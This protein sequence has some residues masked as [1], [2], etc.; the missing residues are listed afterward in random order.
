MSDKD[1]SLR[2]AIFIIIGVLLVLSLVICIYI[3]N[4]E[5]DLKLVSAKV[6]EVKNVSGKNDVTITYKV[7][8]QPYI[9]NF[10]YKKDVQVNDTIDI[11]YHENNPSAVQTFKTSYI[12]FI[13]PVIG[14]ILCLIGLFL[15]FRT[16]KK[17]KTEDDLIKT[18]VISVI[19]NT[20]QLEIITDNNEDLEYVKSFEE[21]HE[22]PVKEIANKDNYVESSDIV[23]ETRAKNDEEYNNEDKINDDENIEEESFIEE[24]IVEENYDDNETDNNDDEKELDLDEENYDDSIIDDYDSLVNEPIKEIQEVKVKRKKEIPMYYYVTSSTLVYEVF[25]HDAKEINLEDITTVTRTINDEDKLIK[26]VIETSEECC[27]LTNMK[28]INLVEVS[29]LLHNRMLEMPHNEIVE[30]KEF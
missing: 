19:G 26:I 4:S 12:I 22:T 18:Q 23:I 16:S 28:G 11:Y 10:F 27:V 25:G 29:N 1:I 14:L 20:Q 7:N 15:L 21:E 8:N 5:K 3:V 9:Y 30:Y 6:I 17:S 13:C 24:E 2:S